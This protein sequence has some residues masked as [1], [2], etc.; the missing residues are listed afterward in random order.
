MTIPNEVLACRCGASAQSQTKIVEPNT[1][2]RTIQNLG[3]SPVAGRSW[4]VYRCSQCGLV[5]WYLE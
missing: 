3:L 4:I 1:T 5:T 2:S